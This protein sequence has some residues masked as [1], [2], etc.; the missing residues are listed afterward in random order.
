[1]EFLNREGA[2]GSSSRNTGWRTSVL[3]GG[4]LA[5]LEWKDIFLVFRAGELGGRGRSMGPTGVSPMAGDGLRPMAAHVAGSVN[6]VARMRRM[7][8][9]PKPAHA[10]LFHP[11][12][13]LYPAERSFCFQYLL[14]AILRE[15]RSHYGFFLAGLHER[16]P[17]LPELLARPHVPLPSR[18]YAV[19]WEDDAEAVQKLDHKRVP[20]L[21]LGSL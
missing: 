6:L 21:E 3:P 19:A 20:Y 12:F 4:L 7:P 2:P 10:G 9:L 8:L 14:E 11:L 1:M 17:L 16:D 15:K 5:H 18:L 13:D